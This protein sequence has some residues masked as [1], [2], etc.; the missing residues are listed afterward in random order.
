MGS[1]FYEAGPISQIAINLFYGWGYNFYRKENQLRAD[2]QLI[3]AKVSWLLGQTRAS[4]EEAETA[5]RREF[6]PTPTRAKPTPD[7]AAV[8]DAQEL[9]RLSKALGDLEGQIRN[10]PVPESDRMTQRYRQEAETLATL[11]GHDQQL[12]GQS[13]LL[14]TMLDQQS[15]AAIIKNLPAIK[16]GL[17]AIGQTLHARQAA[18]L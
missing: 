9:E 13:E 3:R 5:Y 16:E 17:V 4:V 14:R 7:P 12:V 15:G 8:A 10:Q 11:S 2:D 1:K 6:L 18:L